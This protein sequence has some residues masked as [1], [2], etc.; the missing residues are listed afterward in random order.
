[1]PYFIKLLTRK[2][3]ICWSNTKC[4]MEPKQWN[5]STQGMNKY[6]DNGKRKL[7]QTCLYLK[8]K[9]IN[10]FHSSFSVTLQ[11]LSRFR[12]QGFHKLMVILLKC[13]DMLKILIYDILQSNKRWVRQNLLLLIGTHVTQHFCFLPST[14]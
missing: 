4:K 9:N 14:F 10:G 8:E 7:T 11:Q 6:H 13:F 2:Q 1:M 12:Y 3:L 5:I